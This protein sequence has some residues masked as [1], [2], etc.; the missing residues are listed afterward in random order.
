MFEQSYTTTELP[1]IFRCSTIYRLTAFCYRWFVLLTYLSKREQPT[2]LIKFY[3]YRHSKTDIH[4]RHNTSY[5]L[6]QESKNLKLLVDKQTP[7]HSLHPHLLHCIKDDVISIILS[8][9]FHL[10]RSILVSISR[11]NSLRAFCL[12]HFRLFPTPTED[13]IFGHL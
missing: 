1:A 4:S 9:A 11:N 7:T 5:H 10:P 12:P 13:E 6:G 8:G 2:H 3:E